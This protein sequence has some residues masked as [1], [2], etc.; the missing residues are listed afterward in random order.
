[1]WFARDDDECFACERDKLRD[2]V[3]VRRVVGTPDG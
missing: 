3:G 2:V 1:L